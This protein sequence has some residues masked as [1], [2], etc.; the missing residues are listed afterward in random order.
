MQNPLQNFT[1]GWIDKLLSANFLS[2]LKG[3]F[4]ITY[5]QRK[6]VSV[7]ANQTGDIITFNNLTLGA[8]Y[9]ATAYMHLID[10]EGSA[11]NA[12]FNFKNGS[13]LVS[14]PNLVFN[15][16][17]ANTKSLTVVEVFT[18]DDV[19]A[20]LIGN[21]SVNDYSSTSKMTIILEELP[22]HEQTTAWT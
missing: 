19:A 3:L 4:G 17:E 14:T 21:L 13:T 5:W 1:T 10:V 18:A 7:S 9:R 11:E 8:T 2:K 15:P 20:T 12:T 22:N 6:T 16:S